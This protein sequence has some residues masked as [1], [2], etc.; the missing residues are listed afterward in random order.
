MSKPRTV[1]TRAGTWTSDGVV[2]YDLSHDRYWVPREFAQR[3]ERE[4]GKI[5]PLK[6]RR[7]Y[8]LTS[9]QVD[10]LHDNGFII[11]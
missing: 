1:V 10:H 4:V 5:E 11:A 9:K 8:V 7:G 6:D 3:V 2:Q